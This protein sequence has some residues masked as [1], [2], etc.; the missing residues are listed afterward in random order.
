MASI[1]L[2][3]FAK[4]NLSLRIKGARPDGF[5]DV[6]TI[7]Q[8][9][10]LFDRVKCESRR[11]PFQIRCDMPEVPTDH[12]NLSWKAA[13]MLWDTAGLAGELRDTVVTLQKKIPMK[14]GLGGGSSDAAATLLG[15]R[16]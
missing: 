11:G 13:Q 1:T 16:R 9:I 2:R 5:H 12:T 6:Q 4:V 15:L 3:A 8:A 7:L 14:A 10:D